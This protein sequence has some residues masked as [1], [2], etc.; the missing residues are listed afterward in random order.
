MTDAEAAAALATM[1]QFIGAVFGCYDCKMHFLN[2]SS[3]D[4]LCPGLIGIDV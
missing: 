2:M 3:G 4:V 1:H